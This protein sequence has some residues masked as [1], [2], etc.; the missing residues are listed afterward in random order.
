MHPVQEH[1]K[2]L[3]IDCLIQRLTEYIYMNM[4]GTVFPPRVLQLNLDNINR[5]P[6]SK[7]QNRKNQ[8]ICQHGNQT[9]DLLARQTSKPLDHRWVRFPRRQIPRFFLS[10]DLQCGSRLMLSKFNCNTLG[11]K[12]VPFIF[13]Y[14]YIQLAFVLSYRSPV[15]L[16]DVWSH[17]LLNR[18]FQIM[19][20]AV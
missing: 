19:H 10:G 4:K 11:W 17:F 6:H 12:I 8:G 13:I 3:G 16:Y 5:L 7:Y 15:C 9:H 2:T 1:T 20:G 14:I 18:P